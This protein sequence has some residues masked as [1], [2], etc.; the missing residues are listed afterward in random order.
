MGYKLPK[1]LRSELR[2]PIGQLF[3]GS[4]KYPAKRVVKFIEENNSILSISIGDFCTRSLLDIK[5]YPDIVIYDG[6]TKRHS[7]LSLDLNFYHKFETVNPPEWI[8]FQAKKVIENA[9]NFNT[10]NNS[11]VAVRIDGEEDLLI[12]PTITLAP[13]G[14]TIIYGQPPMVNTEEGIVAVVISPSLKNM[15]QKLLEK[16]EFHEEWANGNNNP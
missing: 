14:A 6:K 9:I 7:T 16:F 10:V 1:S 5:F 15:M 3:T 11:R 2:T 8:L 12:I 4:G 13:L